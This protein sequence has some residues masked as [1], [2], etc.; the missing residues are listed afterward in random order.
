MSE[1]RETALGRL[2]TK[3]VNGGT[4]STDVARYW[5]GSIPWI[6]GADFTDAGIGEFRRF[7]SPQ[8]V[9]ETATNVIDRGELLIVTRTGVGKLAIA[10]CDIAISQDITGFYV[11]QKQTTPDFLYHRMRQGMQDLKKLN[12]GTSINGVVRSDLERYPIKLPPLPQ[13]RRIA[14]I[15]ST[16]D[17]AIE[18]TEALIAKE[19]QMKTG[20]LS[21]LF[22]RGVTPEGHLR[23]SH[24]DA[25]KLYHETPLGWIPREWGPTKVGDCLQGIDAG[26]SPECPDTPA[27]AEQWGVLKVGAV[28]PDGLREHENKVVLNPSLRVPAYLVMEGDL[29]FSRANT[30]ELVGLSCHVLTQPRNLMLSD[31]TLRLR[32]HPGR[33]RTRFLF[34]F[35]QTA[36]SRRQI[37]NAATGTSGS[38]KNIS[39]GGVRGIRCLRPELPEQ[40]KIVMRLDSASDAVAAEFA[41]LAKLRQLKQGLMQDL[42]TG[43]VPV[44]APN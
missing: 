19:Q 5:S 15:L 38:M 43:R 44:P 21:D 8:A 22:T 34:W 25:P 20:L 31:K 6:T 39:Q 30:S 9:A 16:V 17:E 3:L 4:P 37:E 29:L 27:A 14:Q 12:Q 26:K 10:P 42:L 24:I 32:V 33:M 35:L 13:Q 18:Q 36:V 40:D 41:H 2:A 7:V 1:W 11:D 28:H 23:P